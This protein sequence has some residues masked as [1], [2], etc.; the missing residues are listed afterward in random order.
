MQFPLL[1]SSMRMIDGLNRKLASL[2][3][4]FTLLMALLTLTIV[5]LRYGFNLGWIALQ[6]SVM[7]LHAMV[8]MLGAAHALRLNEHVRVDIFYRTFSAR[9]KALV[10]LF[11]SLFLLM[12]VTIFLAVISWRYVADSWRLMEA[13]QAAGGLPL[14]FVL[15][16][17]IL[18]FCLTML[19]QGVAEA[20]RQVLLLAEKDATTQG[21]AG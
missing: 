3:S 12:P 15:K 6:E 7:Y 4:W 17:F 19:L 11:G 5:I 9:R 13:S 8:F 20:I 10:D 16:S 1:R 14:V 21:D 18:L 2:I